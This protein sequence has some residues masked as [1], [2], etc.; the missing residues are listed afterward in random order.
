MGISNMSDRNPF[1]P[2]EAFAKSL[3][4]TFGSLLRGQPE[5]HLKRPVDVFLKAVGQLQGIEII[6]KTESAVAD[7]GRPDIAVAVGGLTQVARGQ[8]R[9]MKGIPLTPGKYPER[10]VYEEAIDLLRVGDGEIG[11]V[12]H[13]IWE[14][15]VSGLQVLRSWLNYRMA[16]RSG[17][18]SSDLDAILPERW[19]P[20]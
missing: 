1:P 2:L 20:Q 13:R 6:T 19:T 17:R 18:S 3:P 11:P 8:A 7:V 9:S 14:F 15:S 10:F 16:E 5:D 4:V 12:S